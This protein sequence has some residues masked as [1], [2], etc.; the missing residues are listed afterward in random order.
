MKNEKGTILVLGSSNVDIVVRVDR[1]PSAGETV[2]GE[3]FQE[4]WGGK[5]A[6][7]ALAAARAGAEVHFVTMLGNDA[8]GD[9]YRRYLMESGLSPDGVLRCKSRTGR[10]LIVVGKGGENQ[11]A[12]TPG[13]NRFLTPGRM[14]RKPRLLDF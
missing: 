11:I 1:L 5:G 9:A 13:A 14:R 10:A 12:V 8:E 4:H 3:S 2:M 6:N 7:Q